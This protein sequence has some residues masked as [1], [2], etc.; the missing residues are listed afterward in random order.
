MIGACAGQLSRDYI[1]ANVQGA[2]AGV[3]RMCSCLY[4][5][6]PPTVVGV[7]C[8]ICQED[9]GLAVMVFFA[10]AIIC[11]RNVADIF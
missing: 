8:F 2:A 7:L 6:A 11:T 3:A 1:V 5:S 9:I 10:A 4:V